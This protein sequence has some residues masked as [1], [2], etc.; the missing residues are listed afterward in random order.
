MSAD[1]IVQSISNAQNLNRYS[2]VLNNPLSLVDPSGFEIIDE[3]TV[4]GEYDPECHRSEGGCEALET[5]FGDWGIED[6]YG[7]EVEIESSSGGGGS[8]GDGAYIDMEALQQEAMVAMQIAINKM[9]DEIQRITLEYIC[10]Q[11]GVVCGAD[12][13]G[14]V[15][16]GFNVGN[17]TDFSDGEDL[18][19][20]A[21]D[22]LGGTNEG[23]DNPLVQEALGHLSKSP[24]FRDQLSQALAGGVKVAIDTSGRST[25]D[26]VENRI[27]WNPNEAHIMEGGIASSALLLA[28]EVVHSVRLLEVGL[29]QYKEE[30]KETLTITDQTYNPDTNTYSGNVSQSISVSEA[31]A[32]DMQNKIAAEIGEPHRNGYHDATPIFTPSITNSCINGRTCFY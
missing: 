7:G 25:F 10:N 17:N 20:G 15:D 30:Q 12:V 13:R 6:I 28:H 18:N 24:T 27:Y 5:G 1:P 3:I 4:R 22:P 14:Q 23:F 21:A 2:Y 31:S 19:G 9:L 29:E 11:P 8:A 32:T 16:P 26:P